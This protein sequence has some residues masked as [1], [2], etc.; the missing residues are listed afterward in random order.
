MMKN[1]LCMAV[2][3]AASVAAADPNDPHVAF[4]S[5]EQDASRVVKVEYTL[6]EPAI[7][8]FDVTTNG[9]SIGVENLKMATGDLWRVVEATAGDEKRTIT[10]PAY[11]EWPGYK[12]GNGEVSVAVTA[13]ATNSP[14]AY[15]VIKLVGEDKGART[16]YTAPEQLPGAGGVTNDMYKTDYLVMRRIP[17]AG[18][19]FR[20]GAP[21]TESGVRDNEILHY[22]SLT[23]DYYMSVFEL[24]VGQFRNIT[25]N[26]SDIFDADTFRQLRISVDE[27]VSS[28]TPTRP[29]SSIVCSYFRGT[30]RLWPQD[31]HDIDSSAPL[32][33][34]RSAL[35]LSTLDLPTE[36]EWEF[37]CRAGTLSG[38]YDG[39][40]YDAAHGDDVLDI[41]W[42]YDDYYAKTRD[43]G[44][45][46]PN[47]YG[48]YDLYGN[49][50]EWCLDRYAGS[51]TYA[52]AGSTV[53]A[54]KGPSVSTIG[55][56]RVVRGGYVNY[57]SGLSFMRSAFRY[58]AAYDYDVVNS[59]WASGNPKYGYRLVCTF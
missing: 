40:E 18:K 16:F 37:A 44:L 43:V 53:I 20:M 39:T 58:Y 15:M 30:G 36:A 42:I 2:A 33:L 38:R 19:T 41:A 12:F 50:G 3:C 52:T 6:D 25:T 7:V 56:S 47:G 55:D 22:V 31:G 13:W 4:V 5:V 46:K 48:L 59:G 28:E 21:A 45:L 8:T 51:S 49:V 57:K 32:A 9:V 11:K 27:D 14:P 24:S 29:V 34:F 10:W 26:F 1:L 35:G 17:A 54:P 23:N